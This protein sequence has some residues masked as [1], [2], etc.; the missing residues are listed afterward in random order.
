MAKRGWRTRANA[1]EKHRF[2]SF[3][4]FF[5]AIH[6]LF[7]GT[8]PTTSIVSILDIL[9]AFAKVTLSPHL[10]MAKTK[11]V[12]LPLSHFLL[13]FS[14]FFQAIPL[15]G[16]QTT[17]DTPW[18]VFKA[19]LLEE[20]VRCQ[21]IPSIFFFLFSFCIAE[22]TS[23]LTVL[24]TLNVFGSFEYHSAGIASNGTH[25][26][27]LA[28]SWNSDSPIIDTFG[29]YFQNSTGDY[30]FVAIANSAVENA[31][32]AYTYN[33]T[34][35]EE[36]LSPWTVSPNGTSLRISLPPNCYSFYFTINGIRWPSSGE[37]QT[38]GCN[39][40][41]SDTSAPSSDSPTSNPPSLRT[42]ES[43]TV[44]ESQF[45]SPSETAEESTSG[46]QSASESSEPTDAIYPIIVAVIAV[47][48]VLFTSI[49]VGVICYRQ[50]KLANPGTPLPYV[51]SFHS[52]VN[53]RKVRRDSTRSD[54]CDEPLGRRVCFFQLV[55]LL[56]SCF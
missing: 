53:R 19:V 9:F 45:S 16:Y 3:R 56:F 25:F 4:S 15:F 55:F 20:N 23:G 35:I 21:S 27:Y 28:Y 1:R 8:P 31:T 33:N 37:L 46:E 54:G 38:D 42:D 10:R 18:K 52:H 22:T 32:I 26:Y 41:T 12:I 50:K 14:V 11:E 43:G 30:V 17:F 49:A 29:G 47:G 6:A 24:N 40:A 39:I 44:T 5:L 7:E 13:Y 51:F 48:A 36:P 2:P 34:T